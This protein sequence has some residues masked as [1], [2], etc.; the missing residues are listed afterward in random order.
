MKLMTILLSKLRVDK[1][2]DSKVLNLSLVNEYVRHADSLRILANLKS[3]VKTLEFASTT[4]AIF[5]T[6][7][8]AVS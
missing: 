5:L 1:T 3:R 4:A 8:D 6:K 2:V 7:E